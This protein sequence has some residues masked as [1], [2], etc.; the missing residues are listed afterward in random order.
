VSSRLVVGLVILLLGCPQKKDPPRPQ[1]IAAKD[2]CPVDEADAGYEYH[3]TPEGPFGDHQCNYEHYKGPC[4]LAAV[5][6]DNA[7]SLE[8][9]YVQAKYTAIP[10]CQQVIVS[11]E[12]TA[13]TRATIR[14]ELDKA[15]EVPCRFDRIY[16]GTCNPGQCV[17]E[18]PASIPNARCM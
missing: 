14:A 7:S 17:I 16:M 9:N 15:I 2:P 13:A 3:R 8:N 4:R 5:D 1:P 12:V 10:G 18:M 6:P 11:V